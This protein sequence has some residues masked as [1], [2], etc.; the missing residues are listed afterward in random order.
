[1]IKLKGEPFLNSANTKK[2]I[3]CSSKKLSLQIIQ[4][5]KLKTNGMDKDT[6]HLEPR[7]VAERHVYKRSQFN[8]H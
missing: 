6:T 2:Q 3:L 5:L 1:M 8:T 7:T 4:Y